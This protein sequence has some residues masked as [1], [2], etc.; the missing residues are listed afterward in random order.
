M[1]L[2][3]SLNPPPE[4]ETAISGTKIVPPTAVTLKETIKYCICERHHTNKGQLAGNPGM[5][6]VALRPSFVKHC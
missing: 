4:K 5:N 2:T 6:L 1:S 3:I